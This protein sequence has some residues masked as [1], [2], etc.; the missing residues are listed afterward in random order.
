MRVYELVLE[1]DKSYRINSTQKDANVRWIRAPSLDA[2]K[3]LVSKL[4]LKLWR[5]IKGLPHSPIQI[6]FDNGLDA[7]IDSLGEIVEGTLS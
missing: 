7:V 4:R 2:V 1:N 3:K 5:D 6:D